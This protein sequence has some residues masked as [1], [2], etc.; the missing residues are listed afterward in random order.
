[1]TSIPSVPLERIQNL[2][3]AIRRHQVMLDK[4]LAPLYATETRTL[5]QAV[6]RNRDRFPPDFMFELTGADI[7]A[8]VSQSVIPSK[9]HFGGASPFAFTEQGVSMLSSFTISVRHSKTL[10]EN[11]LPSRKWAEKD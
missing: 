2:I 5:K 10:E 1:M 7:E 9:S 8:L 4:D 11:G 6:R 3:Y